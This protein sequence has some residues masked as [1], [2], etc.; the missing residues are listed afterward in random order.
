[1]INFLEQLTEFKR[2]LLL[3]RSLA[4]YERYNSGTASWERYTGQSLRGEDSLQ[5]AIVPNCPH[6]HLP[7]NAPIPWFFSFLFFLS[8]RLHYVGM[9]DKTIDHWGLS[10]PPAPSP[11]LRGQEGDGTESSDPWLTWVGSHG[12][13]PPAPGALQKLPLLTWKH[14]EGSPQLGNSKGLRSSVAGIDSQRPGIYIIL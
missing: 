2:K 12:N 7:G 8:W 14:L 4:H 1:M 10:Q 5:A 11:L 3:T 9:I 13:Q 6:G